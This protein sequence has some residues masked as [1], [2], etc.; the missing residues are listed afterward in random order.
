MQ[1]GK[2]FCAGGLKEKGECFVADVP[3]R[4]VEISS[5]SGCWYRTWESL[6][7]AMRAEG[8]ATPLALSHSACVWWSSPA[9]ATSGT[10]APELGLRVVVVVVV[11]DIVPCAYLVCLNKVQKA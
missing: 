2:A 5:R 4:K 3:A 8:S 9:A 10:A 6:V 1:G 11:E 7:M